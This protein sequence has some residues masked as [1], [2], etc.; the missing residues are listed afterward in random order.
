MAEALACNR[1]RLVM[2]NTPDSVGDDIGATSIDEVL[3]PM[4]HFLYKTV[5]IFPVFAEAAKAITVLNTGGIG[6]NR[7]SLLGREQEHWQENFKLEWESLSP[8]KGA[9]MGAALGAIPGLVLVSGIALTGG[10][11]LL[12]AGPIFAVMSTLGMGALS[13]GMMGA[14]SKALNTEETIQDLEQEVTHALGKGNWVL[15]VHGHTESEAKLAQTLLPQSR[16]VQ[17]QESLAQQPSAVVAEQINVEKHRKVVEE[18]IASVEK[19][20]NVPMHEM[21]RDIDKID[22]TTTKQVIQEALKSISTATDLD[23]DQI[24]EIFLQ[25]KDKG[26]HQIVSR[27]LEQSKLNRAAW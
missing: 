8:A 11:G 15:I 19:I 18:A 3:S 17:D 23:T 6:N 27:L 26:V 25:N 14:A 1:Y 10:A 21:I 16:I 2:K 13:G 22:D 9:L 20:S 4:D 7:I 5:A 12:V 24:A